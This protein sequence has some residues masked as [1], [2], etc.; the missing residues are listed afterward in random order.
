[1]TQK[2][3]ENK[4]LFLFCLCFSSSGIFISPLAVE[5]SGKA[6]TDGELKSARFGRDVDKPAVRAPT[7]TG[8]ELSWVRIFTCGS[9]GCLRT[10]R[11][12]CPSAASAPRSRSSL[13]LRRTGPEEE[14]CPE[15]SR[16]SPVRSNVSSKV[17][18]QHSGTSSEQQSCSTRLCFH[19]NVPPA[20]R[21]AFTVLGNSSCFPEVLQ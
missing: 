13:R 3:K 4:A 20:F 14:P 19:G 1:M 12:P 6:E 8:R 7:A 9:C 2:R 16:V 11:E 15:G 18:H 17:S 21:A 5:I 10:Q